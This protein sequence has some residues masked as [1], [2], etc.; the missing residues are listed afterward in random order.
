ML[1][2]SFTL[3]LI[4]DG[5]FSLPPD[6][7]V[8]ALPQQGQRILLGMNCLLV[9][10]RERT[11]LVDAGVGSKPRRDFVERYQM[12]WPRRLL[13]E[14]ERMQ[15]RPHNIDAVIL[16]HLHWDHAGGATCANETGEIVPAFPRAQYFV[17]E[18][19]W[20]EATKA[21]PDSEDYCA[22]DFVPL[23]D[24][25]V[26]TLLDGNSEL[27]P[28][29]EMR[30][31]GGHTSGHSIVIVGDSSQRAVFLA[32]LVPTVSMLLPEA[33][34]SYDGNPALL[35]QEKR[36]ILQ[37]AYAKHW[38]LIFQ[39]APQQ[40]AGYLRFGVDNTPEMELVAL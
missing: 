24:A 11:I 31:T 26:L 13:G 27:F 35:E 20:E 29:V 3:D 37:E 9:R 19:E 7:F 14:L 33:T 28:G 4:Q 17:Q 25:G 21:P 5:L 1:F 40:R 15:L 23:R 10:S 38:L 32:D 8:G 39:H 22:E 2:G 6:T 36:K 18:S 12:E 30:Q 16:T 34:M